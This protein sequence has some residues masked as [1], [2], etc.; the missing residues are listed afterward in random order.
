ML[1]CPRPDKQMFFCYRDARR[2]IRRIAAQKGY[3][4]EVYRC[5]QH[6]HLTKAAAVVD[7]SVEPVGQGSARTRY[8]NQTAAFRRWA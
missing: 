8:L 2:A 4:L 6:L 1:V 3:V 5:G 7:L